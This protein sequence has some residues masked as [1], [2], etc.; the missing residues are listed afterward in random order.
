[1]EN[2][3]F[4]QF[5]SFDSDLSYDETFDLVKKLF[6]EAHFLIIPYDNMRNVKKD[7]FRE[8]WMKYSFELERDDFLG[9]FI[10]WTNIKDVPESILQFIDIV[11]K[12]RTYNISGLRLIICSSAERMK[13]GNEIVSINYEK[14]FDELFKMSIHSFICPDNLIISITN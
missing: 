4:T 2:F 1:M 7:Y 12:L 8:Y 14:I 11:N 5:I 3:D 13:T 6:Q 10:E 9:D